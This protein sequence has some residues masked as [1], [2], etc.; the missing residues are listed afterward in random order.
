GTIHLHSFVDVITNSSTELFATAKGTQSAIEQIVGQVTKEFGCSA[1]Q[2][3]V[4]ES[5][6]WDEDS[7]NYD[8]PIPGQWAL[9]YDY[10]CSHPPCQMME[11]RL[12]EVLNIVENND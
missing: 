3:E 8:K 1:V 4:R 9:W 2:F 7:D 10:E 6:C 12:K 5:I 11:N